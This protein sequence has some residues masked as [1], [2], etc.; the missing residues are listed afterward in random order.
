MRIKFELGRLF[1]V[2]LCNLCSSFS[3][4]ASLSSLPF[5]VSCLIFFFCGVLP[6]FTHSLL[7]KLKR[8]IPDEVGLLLHASVTF[9]LDSS[10]HQHDL[11]SLSSIKHIVSRICIVTQTLLRFCLSTECW[12]MN[13]FI[14]ILF[15][16][17]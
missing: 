9:V 4:N 6:P 14:K 1:W 8:L 15:Y 13:L 11:T 16:G 7:Q 5:A 17:K 3:Q 10:L 12:K 2:L